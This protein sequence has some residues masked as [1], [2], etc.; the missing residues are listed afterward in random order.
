MS[1][2]PWGQLRCCSS[3][4]RHTFS[5]NISRLQRIKKEIG[6]NSKYTKDLDLLISQ[7]KRCSEILKN[8]SKKLLV[9]NFLAKLDVE[10]LLEEI[11]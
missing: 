11:Y 5:N 4:L 6:N 9:I 3:F 2:N 7:T 10:D 1:L 8:L